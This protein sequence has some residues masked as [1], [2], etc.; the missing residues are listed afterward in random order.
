MSLPAPEGPGVIKPLIL[1]V[2]I[3]FLVAQLFLFV[4]PLKRIEPQPHLVFFGAILDRGELTGTAGEHGDERVI[5]RPRRINYGAAQAA[6]PY[7]DRDVEKPAYPD[8]VSPGVIK[9]MKVNY[10]PE[11]EPP[12]AAGTKPAPPQ[13]ELPEAPKYQPLRLNPK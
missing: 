10:L 12:P 11:T 4:W 2:L 1:S 9:P 8:A 7:T 3:H 13:L 6:A 5:L